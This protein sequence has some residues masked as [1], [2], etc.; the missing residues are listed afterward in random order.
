MD[1]KTL[2][3]IIGIIAVIFLAGAYYQ[4]FIGI[5]SVYF[6]AFDFPHTFSSY[7]TGIGDTIEYLSGC[8]AGIPPPDTGACS[9]TFGGITGRFNYGAFTEYGC[10]GNTCHSSDLAFDLVQKDSSQSSGKTIIPNYINMYYVAHGQNNK[11]YYSIN[12]PISCTSSGCNGIQLPTGRTST[13]T[14]YK[15]DLTGYEG[16]D[17]AKIY[18]ATNS[19]H[20]DGSYGGV[21]F[22]LDTNLYV[23]SSCTPNWNCGSWSSCLNGQQT[24][25]CTDLNSCGVST[26]KPTESQTCTSTCNTNADTNCDNIVSRTELRD[27][28]LKWINA[29]ISRDELGTAIQ[30]WSS[31]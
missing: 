15:I 5:F 13:T 2:L 9:A 22:S 18:F 24:R 20:S 29:Q 28:G 8:S 25:T 23:K 30:A 26:N 31:G 19:L 10:S 4:K 27:Y 14:Y 17:I 1:R 16:K 6:Y 7:G 11:V 12:S 3:W 21:T